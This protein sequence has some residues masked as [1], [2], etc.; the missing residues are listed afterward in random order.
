MQSHAPDRAPAT[1]AP[2]DDVLQA[3][4]RRLG[5][6]AFR[7]GQREAVQTLLDARR[8]LLV[9]AEK[10]YV[11]SCRPCCCQAPLLSSPR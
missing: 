1:G 11:I 2:N 4:L 5:Y 9:A 3:T 6:D 7:A 10:V 8:L